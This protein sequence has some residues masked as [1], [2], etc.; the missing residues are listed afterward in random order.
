MI[1]ERGASRQ[2]LST[3]RGAFDNH[4]LGLGQYNGSWV[5]RYPHTAASVVIITTF[6]VYCTSIY[7]TFKLQIFPIAGPLS[8]FIFEAN[9]T[10]LSLTLYHICVITADPVS[11]Q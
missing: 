9:N 6:M 3:K 8:C 10:F 1:L 4:P 2:L 11:S 7:Y 5:Y